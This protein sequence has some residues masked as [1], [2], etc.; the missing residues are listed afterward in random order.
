MLLAG[1]LALIS[2]SLTAYLALSKKTGAALKRISIIVL[3][4]VCFLFTVCSILLLMSSSYVVT[5]KGNIDFSVIPA[6]EGKG[7]TPLL[8]A[9]IA[10]FLFM[11]LIIVLYIREQRKKQ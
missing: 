1:F 9:A 10:I 3:V 5:Q 2:A 4:L 6:S 8:I 11:I 7:M